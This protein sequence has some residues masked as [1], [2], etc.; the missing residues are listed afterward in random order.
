MTTKQNNKTISTDEQVAEVTNTEEVK[1]YI[2][3]QVVT[4]NIP[5]R[6]RE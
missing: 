2:A 6:A 4:Y 1:K 5:A 3:S